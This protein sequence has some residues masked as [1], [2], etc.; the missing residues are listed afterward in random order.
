MSSLVVIVLAVSFICYVNVAVAIQPDG[1]DGTQEGS[2]TLDTIDV[3]K[4]AAVSTEI[5]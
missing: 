1:V 3:L 2:I 5:A 4:Q